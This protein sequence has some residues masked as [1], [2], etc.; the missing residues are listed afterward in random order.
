[1]NR[2]KRT[3]AFVGRQHGILAWTGLVCRFLC[4][5]IF[6]GLVLASAFGAD[7]QSTSPSPAGTGLP[8]AFADL[9]GDRRPDLAAVQV[10]RSDASLTDYW[11]QLQLSAAGRQTIL[12]VAPTG[13]LQIA[14]RDVN[15][16]NAL[17]LVLTTTWLGQPVAILLNDGHGGFSRVDPTA[18]PG[19]FSES[20]T[21]WGSS[22]YEAPDS[23]GL[24][25]QWR[26]G[27]CT[28]G[29]HLPHSGSRVVGIP[30]SNC[31]FPLSPFIISHSGRAPP[32]E[33]I[34]L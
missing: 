15:G 30:A 17:D 14:V 29:A 34:H 13:G 9:D 3:L 5:S 22:T 11:I 8:F 18:F 27:I 21:C 20:K 19:A 1:M 23:V 7:L 16:D 24:P 25:S 28:A 31:G 33:V 12:V 2:S 6:A 10:G 32:S 4:L 26:D